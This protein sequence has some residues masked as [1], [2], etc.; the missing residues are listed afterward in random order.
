[1]SGVLHCEEGDNIT[2]Y[3]YFLEAFEAYDGGGDARARKCLKYM[4]L[5]KVCMYVGVCVYI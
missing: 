4:C 3:S 2:A 1:M 5:A